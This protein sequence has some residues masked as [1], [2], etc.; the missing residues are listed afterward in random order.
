MTRANLLSFMS[1]IQTAN[2]DLGT[3]Q[4]LV[5]PNTRAKWQSLVQVANYPVY[6][7]NDEGMTI[8]YPTPFTNQIGTSGAFA[9]RAIFGAWGQAMFCDWA[10][11]DIVVDPYT[12]AANNEV[13]V[14]VNLMTDFI[15]RHWP[16]F[17]IS[18]ASAAQ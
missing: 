13:V 9:N 14:T 7:T 11:Y 15:V 6:L 16:S 1:S 8:G 5:N 4:W 18:D 3:M 12:R 2:A 17:A 10:G